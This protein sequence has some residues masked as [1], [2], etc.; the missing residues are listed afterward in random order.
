MKFE[1]DELLEKPYLESAEERER[2]IKKAVEHERSFGLNKDVDII[3]KRMDSDLFKGDDG[4]R[5]S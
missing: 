1:N 4:G 3:K 2:R 5:W